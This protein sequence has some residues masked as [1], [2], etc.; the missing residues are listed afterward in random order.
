MK[1]VLVHMISDDELMTE[2]S[3]AT[4][5]VPNPFL[6]NRLKA[7]GRL[8]AEMFLEAHKADPSPIP[9]PTRSRG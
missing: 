6:L 1:N 4:K 3:V 2:L 5:L 7:A 8:S 9:S